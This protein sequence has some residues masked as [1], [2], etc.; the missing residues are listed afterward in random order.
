MKHTADVILLIDKCRSITGSD[1][2]T[3]RR[4]GCPSSHIAMWK[5]G[6]KVAQPEDRALLAAIAGLDPVAELARATVDYWEGKPKGDRLLKALGKPSRLTGAVAGFAGAVALAIFGLIIP[7]R[8]DAHA[9]T[10]QLDNRYYVKSGT[11]VPPC[12][13]PSRHVYFRTLPATVF[14]MVRLCYGL[15]QSRPPCTAP[16]LPPGRALM[17]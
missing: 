4:V 7:T 16:R 13:R 6:A 9:L 3:A 8:T 10:P 15:Q 11:P 2:E 1:A 5:S 14:P 17:S 12:H